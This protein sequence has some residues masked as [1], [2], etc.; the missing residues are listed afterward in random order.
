MALPLV[1]L[2]GAG[3]WGA[4]ADGNLIVGGALVV[5]GLLFAAAAVTPTLQSGDSVRPAAF[6][7]VTGFA[8]AGAAMVV[9]AVTGDGAVRYLMA[10][11]AFAALVVVAVGGFALWKGRG[12]EI[13]QP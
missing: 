1:L 3:A 2:A 13:R 5:V 11:G 10:V 8:L 12:M 9:L 6:G 4:F 7:G